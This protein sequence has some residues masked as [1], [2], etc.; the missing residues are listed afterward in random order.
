M[1]DIGR[2][3]YSHVAASHPTS[4]AGRAPRTVAG[5]HRGIPAR[6]PYPSAVRRASGHADC[7][8]AETMAQIVSEVVPR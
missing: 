1:Q 3:I 2:Q 6:D 7:K 8:H 4:S 5:A